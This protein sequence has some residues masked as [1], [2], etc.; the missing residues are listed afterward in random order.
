MTERLILV[1]NAGS[2]SLK[3]AVFDAGAEPLR[4]VL[5]GAVRGIGRRR[6]TFELGAATQAVDAVADARAAARLV[7]ERLFG[8]NALL[9]KERVFATGHRVVHGG[10]RFSRPIRLTVSAFDELKS[11]RALA[12]LHNP[13]ALAVMESVG[14]AFPDVPMVAVFDTAFFHDLPEAAR[15]YALPRDWCERHRIR[16]YGF[17][18]IAHAYLAEALAGCGRRAITL[19]LGQGCSAAALV[20]GRPVDTSMGFTPLE[21]LVMGTRAGDLDPG[22]IVHLMQLGYGARELEDA[23]NRRSGLLGLSGSSD[24]VRELLALEANGDRDAALAL[25]V[26]CT[27]IRKYIGAYTAVLGGLDAIGIGGGVGENSSEIRERV[28]RPFNWL[29]IE[30]DP[31]ANAACRGTSAR[32]SSARSTVDVRVVPVKEEPAIARAVIDV[33]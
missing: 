3:F 19:H 8:A 22:V 17:H 29:G 30:I 33:L 16:R 5:D 4:P 15:R 2:S 20:D 6:T 26:F 31:S 7:L 14:D 21:G 18:G 27:R 32:I 28:L 9:S 11:R 12:P 24:D 13:P 25:E 10:E 1:F 23:L